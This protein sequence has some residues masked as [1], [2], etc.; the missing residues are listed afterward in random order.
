V[1]PPLASAAAG[2]P[3]LRVSGSRGRRAAET[4]DQPLNGP[5]LRVTQAGSLNLEPESGSEDQCQ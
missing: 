2:T 3:R 1:R 5:G 4:Y